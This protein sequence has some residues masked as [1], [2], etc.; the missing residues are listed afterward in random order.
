MSRVIQIR[1][2]SSLDTF[3]N[4]FDIGFNADVEQVNVD[5]SREGVMRRMLGWYKLS[6]LDTKWDVIW[7]QGFFTKE[8]PSGMKF[9]LVAKHPDSTKYEI[10]EGDRNCM[11]ISKISGNYN[12]G[13]PYNIVGGLKQFSGDHSV[14]S[15]RFRLSIGRHSKP[16]IY[17]YIDRKFLDTIISFK[18]FHFDEAH[19][20]NNFISK[21][22]GQEAISTTG[23]SLGNKHFF[24]N[25]WSCDFYLSCLLYTSPSPRDS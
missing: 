19:P 22:I 16:F 3:S 8:D 9:I 21:C 14:I 20:K 24:W 1:M 5:Y 13:E 6:T 7:L 23:G 4:P 15:N 10:Y 18:G 11:G 17:Q 12:I 25:G 2:K